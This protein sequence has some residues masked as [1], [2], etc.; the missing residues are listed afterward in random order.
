MV[1]K[2][3][4]TINAFERGVVNE[5]FFRSLREEEN[6]NAFFDRTR[7]SS[8]FYR[9]HHRG[10]EASEIPRRRCANTVMGARY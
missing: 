6:R 1:S 2:H 9:G 4:Y 10:I 5:I 7:E 3:L 8:S